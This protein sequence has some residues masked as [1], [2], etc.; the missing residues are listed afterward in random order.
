MSSAWRWL[1]GMDEIPAGAESLELGFEH[2][3]PAWGWALVVVAAAAVAWLGYF[4]MSGP[5]RWRCMLASIRAALLVWLA[6]IIL[7]PELVLPRER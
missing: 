7:G 6:I 2:P 1:L 5:L 4:K 3:L